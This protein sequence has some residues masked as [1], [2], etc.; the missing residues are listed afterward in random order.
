MSQEKRFVVVGGYNGR[1]FVTAT[2]LIR[3]YGLNVAECILTNSIPMLL[4][5]EYSNKIIL[6]PKTDGNYQIPA[7]V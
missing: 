6:G 4:P 5:S 1:T 3:L 7:A 2:E